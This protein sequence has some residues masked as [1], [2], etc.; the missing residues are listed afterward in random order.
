MSI[1]VKDGSLSD[2]AISEVSVIWKYKIKGF[3]SMQLDFQCT[4]NIARRAFIV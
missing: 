1:I 2:I 4:I 3:V